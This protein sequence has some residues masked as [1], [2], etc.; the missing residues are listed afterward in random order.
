MVKTLMEGGDTYALEALYI[1]VSQYFP[2]GKLVTYSSSALQGI[3]HG[4]DDTCNLK[5]VLVIWINELFGTSDPPLKCGSKIEW[6]LDNDHMGCLL[7]P[8]KYDWDDV[9]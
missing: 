1:N 6:G 4:W 9:E 5:P 2:S 8:T 7:C 3:W